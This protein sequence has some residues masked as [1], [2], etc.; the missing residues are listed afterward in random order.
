MFRLFLEPKQWVAWF[1]LSVCVRERCL[2]S[3][4]LPGTHWLLGFVHLSKDGCLLGLTTEGDAQ[5]RR[6]SEF[7]VALGISWGKNRGRRGGGGPRSHAP[8]G[9]GGD[10][11]W[12]DPWRE[13]F[14]DAAVGG[15]K[16]DA[17]GS[18]PLPPGSA[19]HF[20]LSS[21]AI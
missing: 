19:A 4:L 17:P 21:A 14:H 11:V 3:F 2:V 12:P 10:P 7:T 20:G 1:G 5:A 13:L 15:Q 16:P 6:I 18:P 9:P 8:E